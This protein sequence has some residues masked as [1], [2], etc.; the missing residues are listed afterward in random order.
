MS[1]FTIFAMAAA[2]LIG[3]IRVVDTPDVTTGGWTKYPGVVGKYRLSNIHATP[4]ELLVASEN[5]LIRLDANHNL[6]EKR[7]LA[8]GLVVYGRPLLSDN[9]MVRM[10]KN[11]STNAKEL[12]LHAIKSS[13]SIV[14]IKLK[15]FLAE[16]E[17][18]DF[19]FQA[20]TPGCFNADGSQLM[21]PAIVYPQ[22]H[23]AVFIFSVSMNASTTAITNVELLSRVDLPELPADF[24]NISANRFVNGSYYLMSKNGTW[25]VQ[26]NG[27]AA[28]LN[29]NWTID[30]F[31]YQDS[32]YIT[33]FED[34]IFFKSGNNGESWQPANRPSKMRYI[35]TVD[36]SFIS[37]ELLGKPYYFSD[38]R[39]GTI[40][41]VTMAPTFKDTPDA[42]YGIQQFK[43]RTYSLFQKEL[44]F[45]ERFE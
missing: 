38:V 6:V 30:C 3:C 16:N 36:T 29:T 22:Y 26:T 15:D 17:S 10:V 2:L 11:D 7:T 35:T 32:L 19:D 28:R 44:L 39:K 12:E 23:Y 41:A 24:G 5:E 43:N 27:S 33:R 21:I 9:L 18:Y 14:R 25:R 20:W 1:K 31:R 45:T 37:Q 34:Y 40:E 42:F 13:G 8:E 4:N